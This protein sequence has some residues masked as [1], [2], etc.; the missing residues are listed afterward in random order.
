M[1]KLLFFS[2]I[3]L[4]HD[5]LREKGLEEIISSANQE[6]V[7]KVVFGGDVMGHSS[8]TAA[9]AL[10]ENYGI[11]SAETYAYI[12]Q[13]QYAVFDKIISGFSGEKHGIHGNHDPTG[14]Y[15]RIQSL[16]FEPNSEIG[17]VYLPTINV[18]GGGAELRYF[19][20]GWDKIEVGHDESKMK[21]A[22]DEKPPIMLWH[23]GPHDKVYGT[24][25]DGSEVK[26]EC[27]EEF[28]KLGEEASINLYGHNHGSFVKYDAAKNRFDI[29]MTT[30]DGFYAIVEYDDSYNP[31]ACEVYKLDDVANQEPDI[32][33]SA[34]FFYE[35]IA[36]KLGENQEN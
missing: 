26:Y 27:P 7:D 20:E 5:G 16:D 30:Q 4:E 6:N 17:K 15:E 19:H 33:K 24:T 12:A 32:N 13:A 22:F 35:Q 9:E 28:K 31:V 25:E 18:G 14:I 29:N 10:E 8:V 1:G 34:G 36:S 21:Q 3:H 11:D 23:Q 2:D